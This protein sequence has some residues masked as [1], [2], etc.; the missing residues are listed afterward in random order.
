MVDTVQVVEVVH[1]ALVQEVGDKMGVVQGQ[2]LAM[3]D[4]MVEGAHGVV[5]LHTQ[6]EG[7]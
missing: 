5:V 1:H 2:G 3:D 6:V 7:S 4:V